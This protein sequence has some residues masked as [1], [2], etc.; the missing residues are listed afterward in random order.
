[1]GTK[2]FASYQQAMRL[3]DERS[4]RPGGYIPF[5][6]IPWEDP[7]VREG[8]IARGVLEHAAFA[9]DAKPPQAL[10]VLGWPYPPTNMLDRFKRPLSRQEQLHG[11]GG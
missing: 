6:S 2:S 10:E 9:R 11:A 3:A 8:E 1:M 4:V 5:T 7:R